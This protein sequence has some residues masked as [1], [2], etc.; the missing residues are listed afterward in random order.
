[1][2]ICTLTPTELLLTLFK[3]TYRTIKG[4]VLSKQQLFVEAPAFVSADL[5]IF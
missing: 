2:R 3:A 1:L 4:L 5:F